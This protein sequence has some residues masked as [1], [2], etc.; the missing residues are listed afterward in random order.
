MRKILRTLLF[1]L[2]L[3]LVFNG[4]APGT[5]LETGTGVDLPAGIL[6]AENIRA[7]FINF[8][9]HSVTAL[10]RQ[11]SVSYY[12][13]DGEI[14]QLRKGIVR[15]GRWRITD[16]DRIC[17]K[18]ESFP[19]KCRIIVKEGGVYNKYI[20]K[21]NGKHQLSVHYVAFESGNPLGL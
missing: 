4:V 10:K 19:E 15:I 9:V 16:D 11:K 14:R 1:Q 5:H 21:K 6:N 8:T 17:L 2:P 20:V 12:D 3:L 18:M 7:L 13:P